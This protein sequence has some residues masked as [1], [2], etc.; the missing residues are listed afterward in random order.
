M[1]R[2]TP[3][4]SRVNLRTVLIC[5]IPSL[6]PLSLVRTGELAIKPSEMTRNCL[7]FACLLA[8]GCS[9]NQTP[10]EHPVEPP[11]SLAE[12]PPPGAQN[13][14][15]PE[16]FWVEVDGDRL[17]ASGSRVDAATLREMAIQEARAG[18]VRG[19]ALTLVGQTTEQQALSTVQLLLAAGFRHVVVSS[20]V[21]LANF[22]AAPPTSDPP[23]QS[24]T[25]VA[26][27]TGDV[28]TEGEAPSVTDET[29]EPPQVASSEPRVEVKQMGLHIGGGP[30]DAESHAVYAEP[31]ARRF[32]DIRQCYTLV[33]EG[34]KKASFGVDLLIP[35]RGGKPRIENYRT[36]IGG[37]DFHLCVLGVFGSIEFKAPGKATMVSYSVLFKP[38]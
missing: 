37:K 26:P 11:R 6:R 17:L 15:I 34:P 32:E 14:A 16:F 3:P 9:G 27:A 25:P 35:S 5:K 21:G 19:A 4:A 38:L 1:R 29:P 18:Q 24:P 28:P 10:A 20:R 13:D 30:N 8:L 2:C 33:A 31:I 23:N 7:L 22:T 12:A 36:A